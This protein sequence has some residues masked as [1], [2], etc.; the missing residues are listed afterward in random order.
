M[1]SPFVSPFALS[2]QINRGPTSLCGDWPLSD[3]FEQ[4]P[5]ETALQLASFAWPLTDEQEVTRLCQCSRACPRDV[6]LGEFTA[7]VRTINE[8]V[9]G[10]ITLSIDLRDSD[11]PGVHARMDARR[12]MPLIS[13]SS[14]PLVRLFRRAHIRL[15]A[16]LLLERR[17]CR[18]AVPSGAFSSSSGVTVSTPRW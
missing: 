4:W 16:I 11:V 7:A 15:S 13:L 3:I 5:R 8:G 12:V 14:C 18:T 17:S 2:L 10:V 1:L 9:H 6:V